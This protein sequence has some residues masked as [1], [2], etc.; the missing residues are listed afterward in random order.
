MDDAFAYGRLLR[1]ALSPKLRPSQDPE[2]AGLIARLRSEP[3]LRQGFGRMLEGAGLLLLAADDYGVVLGCEHDG[4][5]A[6][7]LGDFRSSMGAGDRLVY[8]LLQLAIAAWCFPRAEQLEQPSAAVARVAV[9]PLLQW[10][11][12]LCQTLAD[13]DPEDPT[14]DHP[15]LRRAWRELLRRAP[16]RP[17][18]TGRRSASSLAGMLVHCLEALEAQGLMRRDSD[19]LGGTWKSTRAYRVQVREL[20]ANAA[21]RQ[22]R[23]A[24]EGSR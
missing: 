2:Y 21:F 5:F 9:H 11:G 17:T 1:F 16:A 6:M 3:S 7:K 14:E 19:A 12:E 24:A 4:P 10:L 20:G 13:D 8:G 15:E 23:A 22:V 18:A